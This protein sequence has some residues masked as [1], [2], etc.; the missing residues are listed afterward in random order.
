MVP[1]DVLL[2]YRLAE[3]IGEGGMGQVWRATD[4]TLGR[5]VAIKFLPAAFADDAERLLRFEREAKVLAAL[6]HPHIAAIY[7]FHETRGVR[8]LVMELVSGET[9]AERIERGRVPADEARRIA[10]SIASALEYAHEHGIVHRDLK[11]SNVKVAEDGT[12]KVLDFGLAKAISGEPSGSS[13]TSTPTYMPTVTS[14][15]TATGII[16]GTAAYMSPEQARGKAV[17]RR[18]DI[19]AFGVVLYEMLAGRRLFDGETSSDTIAAVLTQPIDF[20]AA[21]ASSPRTLRALVRRCLDR[22][23]RA[24]L[25]DIGEA[26]IA[27]EGT[28]PAEVER[29]PR[30][31]WPYALGGA[32]AGAVF[33]FTVHATIHNRGGSAGAPLIRATIDLPGTLAPVAEDRA[34]ALSPDGTRIAVCARDGTGSTALYVRPLGS[35]ELRPVA[36]A[37]GCTYPFWSPDGKSLGFFAEGKLKRVDLSD[38]I[39]RVLCDAPE[40]RGGSW[41]SKG[42]IAFAP[43]AYGPIFQVADT[44]GTPNALTKLFDPGESQRLPHFLPDGRRFLFM[45]TV[46]ADRSKKGVYLFDPDRDPP[47]LLLPSRTE[48]AFVDPGYLAYVDGGNVMLR[49]LDPARA[50]LTGQ[51]RPIAAGANADFNRYYINLDLAAGGALVYQREPPPKNGTLVW[52]DRAGHETQAPGAASRILNADLSPDEKTVALSMLTPHGEY[53][54]VNLDLDRGVGTGLGDPKRSTSGGAWSPDGR[55]FA[56]IEE[57][58]SGW[59]VLV[60][61]VA[62]QAAP[63]VVA[64]GNFEYQVG[65]FTS[66]GRQLLIER[67]EGTAKHGTVMIAPVDGSSP[68]N[69]LIARSES[70]GE[71]R[72]SPGGRSLAFW[73]ELGGRSELML[74]AFP[75]VGAIE[76]VSS[77]GLWR[78]Q[79]GWASDRELWWIDANAR[80]WTAR[81][82]PHGAGMSIAAPTPLFGGKATADSDFVT[83]YSRTRDRFLVVREAAEGEVGKLIYV[84]DWKAALSAP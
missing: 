39:V 69:P 47:R 13:P 43:G 54:V 84:S 34:I 37:G 52:F 6:N 68:P 17:D 18:A 8:F 27:L 1:G 57:Q 75:E 64:S 40:G 59:N 62:G 48:A 30:R 23:V 20:D 9:L 12:V 74:T 82:E 56:Y 78:D 2:H 31:W 5:D 80:G 67:R 46:R 4:T 73:C 50:E 14:G 22:D 72:L 16:L 15:N 61:G 24:R 25:R 21:L 71:P 10:L 79:W 28:G 3:P 11:P 77:S 38:G 45:S 53:E 83:C 36:A 65:S 32:L 58:D 29:A 63:V 55:S 49:P 70:C 7:G 51:A 41:G 33:T 66:D 76:R 19:W 35:L 60:A 44:G 81:L 42:T 26:R